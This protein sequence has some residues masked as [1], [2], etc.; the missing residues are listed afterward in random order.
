MRS[1]TQSQCFRLINSLKRSEKFQVHKKSENQFSTLYVHV[2]ALSV[3]M[4]IIS[5]FID[6][7]EKNFTKFLMEILSRLFVNKYS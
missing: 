7:D 2:L 3:V 6:R 5:E 1:E 4:E